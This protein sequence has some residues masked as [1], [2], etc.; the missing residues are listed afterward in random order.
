MSELYIQAGEWLN[1]GQAALLLADLS[2]LRVETTDLNEIDVARLH[3]GDVAAVT[4]DALPEV[5]FPGKVVRIAPKAS[6]GA[7]V[8]YTVVIELDELPAG[9]RWGMTAFVEIEVQP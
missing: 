9:L 3:I 1:P 6:T 7:G 2:R 8:N 4:F 5:T